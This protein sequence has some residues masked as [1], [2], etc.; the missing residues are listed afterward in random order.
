MVLDSSLGLV[1]STIAEIFDLA[2]RGFSQTEIARRTGYKSRGSIYD[3]LRGRY[4]PTQARAEQIAARR[5]T[6]RS[7]RVIYLADG[8]QVSGEP[9]TGRD[10]SVIAKYGQAVQAYLRTGDPFVLDDPSFRRPVT[11]VSR[12]GRVRVRLS[13]DLDFIREMGL[14]DED[15]VEFLE[16]ETP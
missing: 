6:Y 14:Q 7:E 12:Q 5:I 15:V 9:A 11:L 10:A 4:R 3:I 2:A 13:N 1:Q 8:S 16:S